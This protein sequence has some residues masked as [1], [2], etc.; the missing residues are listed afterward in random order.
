MST[1]SSREADEDGK[2]AGRLSAPPTQ[3]WS[4]AIQAMQ[5]ALQRL[6]LEPREAQALVCGAGLTYEEA[7]DICGCA[8]GTIK[9][10]INRAR[11]RLLRIMDADGASDALVGAMEAPK[12]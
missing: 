6:P 7:A 3:D 9:S 1:F 10:R 12:A 8:L 4:V 11:T 5:T 2:H